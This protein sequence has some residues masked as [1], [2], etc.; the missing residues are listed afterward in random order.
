ML[1]AIEFQVLTAWYKEDCYSFVVF[2]NGI[3]NMREEEQRVGQ[4]CLTFQIRYCTVASYIAY[5]YFAI[6]IMTVELKI[7]N[8][9]AV[10]VWV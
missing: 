9:Y 6:G 7:T 10:I 3:V 4:E 1:W 2:I 5:R 8:K